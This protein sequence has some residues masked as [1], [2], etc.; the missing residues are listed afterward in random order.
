MRSVY[1][2][3]CLDYPA[4]ELQRIRDYTALDPD[5][6][7]LAASDADVSIIAYHAARLVV[8][9]ALGHDP[10]LYP[11][12][13]YLIGLAQWWVFKAPFHT[14]PIDTAGVRSTAAETAHSAE[15][16]ERGFQFLTQLLEKES[17][18]ASSSS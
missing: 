5:G 14:I 13:M 6:H 9:T 18:A 12:S 4:P 1:N 7:V 8:D 15:E 3:Y 11:Y 17:D 16:W 2:Q 10:S